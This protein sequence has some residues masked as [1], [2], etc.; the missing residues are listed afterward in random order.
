MGICPSVARPSVGLGTSIAHP[1]MHKQAGSSDIVNNKCSYR[2]KQ[3][4]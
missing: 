1:R 2:Q 4:S 3:T